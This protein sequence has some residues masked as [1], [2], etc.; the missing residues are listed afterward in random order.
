MH[1]SKSPRNATGD[2]PDHIIRLGPNTDSYNFLLMCISIGEVQLIERVTSAL[3]PMG[4]SIPTRLRR[5][6]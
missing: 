4:L 3:K 6:Y 1:K 5:S 2:E